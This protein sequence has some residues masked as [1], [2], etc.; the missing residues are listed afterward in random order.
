MTPHKTKKGAAALDKMKVFEGCPYPYSH[1]KKRCVPR[2]LK[3]VRLQSFR[4]YCTLGDL[5]KSIG[6]NKAE[7]VE[8]L[9]KKRLERGSEYYQSKKKMERAVQ[10]DLKSN[11]EVQK[12][13]SE[14]AQFGYW[15]YD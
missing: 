15:F 8:K 14:L 11:Q 10:E 13:R 4:K 2:A 9:E 12:L 3:A 1:Q 6:W 5:C 7:V